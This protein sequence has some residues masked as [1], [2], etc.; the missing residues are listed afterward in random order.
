MVAVAAGGL[1]LLTAIGVAAWTYWRA[2]A[3]ALKAIDRQ[4]LAGAAGVCHVIA[5]D[6]HDRAT[7]AGRVAP[8]EDERNIRALTSLARK[9]GFKFLYT[10]VRQSGMVYITSSSATAEELADDSEVHCFDAYGEALS[11]TQDAFA[12]TQV[13]FTTY[14]DRWGV[15]RAA[16]LPETSPVGNR[17][18]AAAE[19]DIGFIRAQLRGK[20]IESVALALV[21]LLSS[22]PFFLVYVRK[23]Q[24]HAASL[25]AANATLNREMRERKEVERQLIQAHKMEAIGTLAGG[26]AHDFNNILTS[27]IGHAELAAHS[28]DPQSSAAR[29]LAEI[30]HAADRAAELTRRILTF[31]RKAASD[32]KPVCVAAVAREVVG[33][34]QPTLPSTIAVD[35]RLNSDA[36]VLADPISIHQVLMNL[37]T[38]GV[39]AMGPDGGVLT[40]EVGAVTLSAADA[41]VRGGLRAGA[42]VGIVV[43]DTGAGIAPQVLD[44]IFEPYF[45]TKLMGQGTGLGLAVVHGIVKSHGGDISVASQPGKGSAFTV[46]LPRTEAETACVAAPDARDGE[47][48]RGTERILVV[49]DEAAIA[50][51]TARS[52]ESLGYRVTVCTES[53]RALELF[54]ASPEA[55]DLVLTDLIM[56]GLTGEKLAVALAGR[57]PGLPIILCTGYLEELDASA[58]HGLGI[59]LLILKPFNR[60]DLAFGLRSTLDGARALAAEAVKVR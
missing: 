57:R 17:Y 21:L 8:E 43:K 11:F 14:S 45:T 34:L 37:C 19:M 24:R 9:A 40:V 29:D 32:P 18:L 48:P 4:L 49:D 50:Q 25:E 47:L 20:L 60:R 54:G 58:I 55:F 23:E 31:A 7:L 22:V 13:V 41:E 56:P 16:Y 26:V 42:Y 46:L 3:A 33:L 2:R 6:F 59:S 27:I 1:Y 38:N 52:I 12:A 51:A 15:F 5:D 35:L 28:L 36:C 39:Q 44:S 30:G 53:T 10:L